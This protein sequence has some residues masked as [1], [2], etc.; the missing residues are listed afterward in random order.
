[1]KFLI[2]LSLLSLNSL[3]QDRSSGCGMGWQVTRSMSTTASY[4]RALTN[5]TFSNTFAMTSG[6]SG[7]AKHDLVMKEREKIFYVEANLIPLKREIALGRGERIE[8]LA[9]VWGC[10][11]GQF[12]QLL[13]QNYRQLFKKSEPSDVVQQIDSLVLLANNH[14]QKV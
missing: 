14:C 12:S 7:C 10:E 4:T 1:M 6:T 13:K 2:F 3:A 8:G 5:A 9:Q 11:S